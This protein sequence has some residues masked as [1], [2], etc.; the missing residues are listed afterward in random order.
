MLA[1][2]I[3]GCW[4]TFVLPEHICGHS[5]SSLSFHFKSWPPQEPVVVLEFHNYSSH[6]RRML[7]LL[8]FQVWNPTS[9]VVRLGLR[10]M[11]HA[12]NM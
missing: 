5:V 12:G 3:E 4:R 9:C 2:L 7:D 11:E 6:L 8:D 10:S 1:S